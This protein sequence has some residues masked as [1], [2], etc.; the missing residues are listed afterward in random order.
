MGKEGGGKGVLLQHNR[1][2]ALSTLTNQ[3]VLDDSN[4]ACYSVENHGMDNR[5]RIDKNGKVQ[6]LAGQMGTGGGNVPLTLVKTKAK[7][8]VRR[9]T[10]TEC[11]RLQGFPDW[12]CDDLEDD[13]FE[14][15]RNVWD[16]YARLNNTKPKT[17]KAVREWMKHPHSDSAEYKMWGNG[18]ALPCVDFI[19]WAI[20]E[21]ENENNT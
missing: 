4:A 17:D 6:T 9:L 11:A 3:Y 16:E 5:Y 19:L 12:W 20:K 14:F 1:T 15:W 7:Y 18:V 2:G 13:D 10:P 8:R 21:C